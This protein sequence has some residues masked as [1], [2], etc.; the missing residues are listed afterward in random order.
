MKERYQIDFHQG[1]ILD[2]IHDYLMYINPQDE[3]YR[4]TLLKGS[5]FYI[6]M[7]FHESGYSYW[8][9][10]LRWPVDIHNQAQGIITGC[11][12]HGF[13]NQKKYLDFSKKIFDWTVKNMQDT[14]GYFYYQKWPFFINR[15]SYMR[16]GQAW[17][18]LALSILLYHICSRMI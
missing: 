16:W 2:A 12:L 8:R 11:K 7:Q 15:I 3:K 9:L 18:M 13:F 4:K 10:P 6:T 1:F 5:I 17:M 14:T